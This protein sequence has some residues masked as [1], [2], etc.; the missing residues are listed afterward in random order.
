[1]SEGPIALLFS[2]LCLLAGLPLLV[3]GLWW[4]RRRWA[5]RQ[6]GERATVRVVGYE[7][8]RDFDNTFDWYHPIV[9]FGG[10][11]V[12]LATGETRQRWPP[13]SLLTVCFR[14]DEAE[15]M[16]IDRADMLFFMPVT[17][18]LMGA[19]LIGIAFL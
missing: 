17:I 18:L 16:V 15:R 12:V 5:L 8:R 7:S 14:P 10:R 19:G 13:G 4:L 6:G 9:V 1:M 3:L 2:A 11:R